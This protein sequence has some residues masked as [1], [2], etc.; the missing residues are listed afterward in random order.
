[1]KFVPSVTQKKKVTEKQTQYVILGMIL[2][3]VLWYV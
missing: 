3:D 2:R 1:M